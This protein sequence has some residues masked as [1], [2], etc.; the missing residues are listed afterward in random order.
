[1]AP[2]GILGEPFYKKFQNVGP[3][4]HV[5]GAFLQN[6]PK[7]WPLRA[8]QGSPFTKYSNFL[9]PAGILGEPFY[10]IFPKIGPC[11]HIKGTLLQN[12]QN[13]RRVGRVVS[14]RVGRRVFIFVH[15][16]YV[17]M[18]LFYFFIDYY[19]ILHYIL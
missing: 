19:C 15:F 17:Y 14:R 10:N 9:A 11:G 6:I 12:S 2:A 18:F 3:Y 7:C 16:L 1:M 5:R 4:G 13:S 8:Y